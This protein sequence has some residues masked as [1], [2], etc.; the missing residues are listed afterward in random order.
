M[1]CGITKL[2]TKGQIIIPQNIRE[3]MNLSVNEQFVIMSENNEIIIKSVKDVLKIDRKKSKFAED[4]VK[5]IRHDKILTEMENGKDF[6]AKD[7]L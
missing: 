3:A 5:A 6:S 1:E 4:F 7:I 2:S